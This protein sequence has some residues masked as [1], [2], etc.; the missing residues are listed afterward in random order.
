MFL[1]GPWSLWWYSNQIKSE[2]RMP[3][4][5]LNWT[6]SLDLHNLESRFWITDS[7]VIWNISKILSFGI[8]AITCVTQFIRILSECQKLMLQDLTVRFKPHNIVEFSKK[9]PRKLLKRDT[10]I[11]ICWMKKCVRTNMVIIIIQ[12]GLIVIANLKTTSVKLLM[13]Q[14]DLEMTLKWKF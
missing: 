8:F 4:N 5:V 13:T 11:L 6:N 2:K 7:G 9:C 14:K 1:R 3:R 10:L 12:N